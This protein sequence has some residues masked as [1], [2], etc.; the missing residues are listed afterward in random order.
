MELLR[1]IHSPAQ[2]GS[3][4]LPRG[5]EV[6]DLMGSLDASK[7]I[8]A[9][10]AV[11]TIGFHGWGKGVMVEEDSPYILCTHSNEDCPVLIALLTD[12][13]GKRHRFL[14][15][16]SETEGTTQVKSFLK[17][18]KQKGLFLMTAIF[19]PWTQYP[20]QAA[21]DEIAKAYRE[22][23]SSAQPTLIERW[24][25]DPC[26][27]R[28]VPGF[29]VIF[30]SFPDCSKTVVSSSGWWIKRHYYGETYNDI[31]GRWPSKASI[32]LHQSDE[33]CP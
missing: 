19:S 33:Y 24:S 21:Q 8:C 23:F 18:I 5:V 22:T 4:V 11:I 10:E 7:G 26:M 16:I 12:S 25:A 6:F 3:S 29:Y 9:R 13:D 20:A 28:D 1:N 32:T 17:Q 30:R 2:I 31:G 15:H 14:A 27:L